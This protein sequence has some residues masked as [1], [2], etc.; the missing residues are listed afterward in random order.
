MEDSN[1]E[2]KKYTEKL[3]STKDVKDN[4]ESVEVYNQEIK[5]VRYFEDMSDYEKNLIT[6]LKKIHCHILRHYPKPK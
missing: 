2:T 5:N 4:T 6:K 3:N 1:R